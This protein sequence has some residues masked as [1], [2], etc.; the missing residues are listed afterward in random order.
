MNLLSVHAYFCEMLAER[1]YVGSAGGCLPG[2]KKRSS[3]LCPQ[4]VS[5]VLGIG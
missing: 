2:G 1:P 4:M 5:Q 3:V